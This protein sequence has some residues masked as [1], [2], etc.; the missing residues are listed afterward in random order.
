MIA[1]AL[2]NTIAIIFIL[3]MILGFAY[4]AMCSYGNY[5]AIAGNEFRIPNVADA[6]YALRIANTGNMLFTNDLEVIDGVYLL[7]GFWQLDKNEKFKF[8]D[9]EIA[10]DPKIFGRIEVSTRR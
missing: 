4:V 1:G 2:K 6:K 10:I 8:T 3:F 5:Q 9:D 7:D